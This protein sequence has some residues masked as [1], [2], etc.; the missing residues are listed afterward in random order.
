MA[1]HRCPVQA[2]DLMWGASAAVKGWWRCVEHGWNSRSTAH[3]RH[4]ICGSEYSQ[5]VPST[6][7]RA[8]HNG[9]SVST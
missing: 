5:C 3:R 7:V 4:A 1:L 2:T 6:A 9:G 8:L